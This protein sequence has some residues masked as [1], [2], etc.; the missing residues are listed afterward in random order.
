[1]EKKK[2]RRKKWH[3]Y[4][5]RAHTYTHIQHTPPL[6]TPEACRAAGSRR[7]VDSSCSFAR[8][9]FPKHH[10]FRQI[11][12][13]LHPRFSW[14][15]MGYGTG[16]I[17]RRDAVIL[18]YTREN[19]HGNTAWREIGGRK[20]RMVGHVERL[21]GKRWYVTHNDVVIT[22]RI[23]HI[24]EFSLSLAKLRIEGKKKKKK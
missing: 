21:I 1:M 18:S 5:A 4:C 10:F 20:G 17:T 2:K 9:P 19:A 12:A 3:R 7:F 22:Y 8:A 6:H 15:A 14:Y 16:R 11:R 23:S 24:S 13:S